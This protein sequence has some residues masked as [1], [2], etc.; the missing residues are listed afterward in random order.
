[1]KL[2]C[3]NLQHAFSS[4]SSLQSGL[5]LQN[6]SLSTHSPLPQDNLPSG[7]TGS[8]VLNIGNILRGSV[9]IY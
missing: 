7:H 4:D 6:K 3:V 1:M 5:P 8:S 2:I 9:I